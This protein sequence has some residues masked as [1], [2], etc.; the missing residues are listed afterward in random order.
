MGKSHEIFDALV[1]R[2]PVL[3]SDPERV[4]GDDGGDLRAKPDGEIVP[5][6]RRE[7]VPARQPVIDRGSLA[8]WD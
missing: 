8:T 6:H 7:N 1:R 2:T 3:V 4:A 5:L